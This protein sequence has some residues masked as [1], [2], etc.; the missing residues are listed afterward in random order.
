LR[1]LASMLTTN[2]AI[3]AP[4]LVLKK[5]SWIRRHNHDADQKHCGGDL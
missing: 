1:A 2:E 3:I 4:S 5:P